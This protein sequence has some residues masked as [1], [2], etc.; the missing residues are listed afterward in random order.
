MKRTFIISL[1]LL[2]LVSIA[3]YFFYKHNSNDKS[4][5]TLYGNVDIREVQVSFR[6]FGRVAQLH[7]D[8]GDRVKSGT[9]LAELD[10]QPLQD[11]LDKA[12]ADVEA[13]RV[14]YKN[15][16]LIFNRKK[17]L[18][19]AK[20][21][22]EENYYNALTERDKTKAS[23]A[24][25]EE[26]FNI[27]KTNLQDATLFA[28]SEGTIISRIREI[29]TVVNPGE[30]VYTLALDKPLWIRAYVDEPHLGLI[31]YG[32]E[33]S[34]FTDTHPEKKFEGVIGFISPVAE[35]TPKNVETPELRANLVYRLR[36]II[37]NSDHFLLQGM[38][39][40]IKIRLKK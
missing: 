33:A 7:Y 31:H 3:I 17:E 25:A 32:M 11:A 19:G 4:E 27:A 21:I 6:V 39:V 14:T 1:L 15:A 34:V 23:L 10:R 22:S 5:L 8:E 38:P 28:P 9:L 13:K 20:Y 2:L 40:T 26:E 24:F 30:P 18:I 37:K 16:D 12:C 36:I 29:G 35:F